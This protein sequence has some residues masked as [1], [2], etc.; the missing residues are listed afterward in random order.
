MKTNI[1]RDDLVDCILETPAPEK[2]LTLLRSPVAERNVKEMLSVAKDIVDR[3]EVRVLHVYLAALIAIVPA[4]DMAMA[5]RRKAA[6]QAHM[7]A[8]Y[9]D[10]GQILWGEK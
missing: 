3:S 9:R 8:F 2:L 1:T 7:A 6:P 5:K 10:L 4:V